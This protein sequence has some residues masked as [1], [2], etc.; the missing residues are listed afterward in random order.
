MGDW[1]TDLNYF[2]IGASSKIGN[3]NIWVNPRRRGRCHLKQICTVATARENFPLP[4]HKESRG[5][6]PQGFLVA[7]TRK[8]SSRGYFSEIQLNSDF[9]PEKRGGFITR[10]M[11]ATPRASP[12]THQGW[13]T[14]SSQLHSLCC[15]A[16]RLNGSF[17][18]YITISL[19]VTMFP[20]SACAKN[21]TTHKKKRN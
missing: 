2:F 18:K 19:R 8:T 17:W 4:Q 9:H 10:R 11:V 5:P 20:L 1:K 21:K 13:L 16:G 15:W 6:E 7:A 12:A 14:G 3:W